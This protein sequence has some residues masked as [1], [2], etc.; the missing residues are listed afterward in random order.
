MSRHETAAARC[1]WPSLILIVFV[2]TT[3]II[4]RCA[5]DGK[6]AST[7][8]ERV[9]ARRPQAIRPAAADCRPARRASLG[10]DDRFTDVLM[11]HLTEFKTLI[12]SAKP[13]GRIRV[14]VVCV[15]DKLHWGQAYC[16]NRSAPPDTKAN[17]VGLTLVQSFPRG[18]FIW[19]PPTTT[20][21]SLG[22]E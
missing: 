4:K 10:P 22:S 5:P 3:Y 20:R 7:E 12:K 13:N 9:G 6:V 15:C 2:S 19:A 21:A 1:S 11:T 8:S 16:A 14:C 17:G 18:L